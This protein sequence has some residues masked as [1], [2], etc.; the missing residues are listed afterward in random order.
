MDDTADYLSFAEK[1]KVANKRARI[2]TTHGYVSSL[3]WGGTMIGFSPLFAY[4]P[5]NFSASRSNIRA[6]VKPEVRG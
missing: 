3:S 5:T 1:K 6:A 4:S 2:N